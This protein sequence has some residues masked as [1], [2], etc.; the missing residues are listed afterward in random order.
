MGV[1]SADSTYGQK[2]SKLFVYLISDGTNRIGGIE[3][4]K[5]ISEGGARE[6]SEQVRSGGRRGKRRKSCTIAFET[7]EST[8]PRNSFLHWLFTCIRFSVSI[9]NAAGLAL[10][11]RHGIFASGKWFFLGEPETRCRLTRVLVLTD[12]SCGCVEVYIPSQ[13]CVLLER[14][15]VN[16]FFRAEWEM[17]CFRNCRIVTY[18]NVCTD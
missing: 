7:V 15:A 16:F 6:F 9:Y 3:I 14:L 4:G 2:E 11:S 8:P 13:G 18:W 17:G 12:R 5:R 10:A 1:V